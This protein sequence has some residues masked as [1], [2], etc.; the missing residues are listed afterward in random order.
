MA[1]YLITHIGSRFS[2]G[3][4][5]TVLG[6]P[7]LNRSGTP[8]IGGRERAVLRVIGLLGSIDDL[9]EGTVNR[10]RGV[11]IASNGQ[12]YSLHEHS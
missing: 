2:D 12:Q 5:I 4:A 11:F 10:E 6:P 3:A 8:V 7:F 1:L 9:I